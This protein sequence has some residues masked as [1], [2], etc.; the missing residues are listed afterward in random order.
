MPLTAAETQLAADVA[1]REITA[2]NLRAEGPLYF[3]DV[4]MLRDKN[5]PERRL[6]RV[7]HYRYAGALTITTLVDLSAQ[8]VVDQRTEA[9]A[10][11]PLSAEEWEEVRRIALADPRVQEIIRPYPNVVLEP[12][13]LQTRSREDPIFGRRVVDLLF[14]VGRDYLSGPQ[15]RVDLNDRSVT[16]GT[17][18]S[19]APHHM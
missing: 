14:R 16:A 17:R 6:A 15:V 13:L 9:N 5:A 12:M 8:R 19:A 18:T 4:E 3:V 11:T 2:R 10:I 7:T 1:G